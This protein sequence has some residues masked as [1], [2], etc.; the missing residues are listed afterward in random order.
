MAVAVQSAGQKPG[1]KFN[2]NLILYQEY[3]QTHISISFS[4]ILKHQ[5]N[6]LWQLGLF[7]TGLPDDPDARQSLNRK[8]DHP[9]DRAFGT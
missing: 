1:E 4:W 7:T 2:G 9:P 5:D 3:T 8:L 6:E